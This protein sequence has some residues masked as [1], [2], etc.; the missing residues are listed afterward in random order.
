[1]KKNTLSLYFNLLNYKHKKVFDS[2]KLLKIDAVLSGGTALSLQLNH[3]KSYD[4]DLFISKPIHKSYLVNV[5]RIYDNKITLITDTTDELSFYTPHN[6]KVSI[7]F[8]P[9]KTLY[10]MIKTEII[11]I[12]HWKDIASDKAYSIGRR[13]EYRDYVDLFFILKKFALKQIIADAQ[14]KFGDTFSVK[15]FLSQ[16]VYLNDIKDF[17]IDFVNKTFSS[18]E[19][20]GFFHRLVDSYLL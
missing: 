20:K 8:F 18:E 6:I 17:T 7:I 12:R 4:F 10:P 16:L 3:R 1:M 9:Y 5:Q 14:K 2:F 15:L 19:I 11:P 13:G